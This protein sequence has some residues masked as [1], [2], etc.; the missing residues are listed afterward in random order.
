MNTKIEIKPIDLTISPNIQKIISMQEW[1]VNY[2]SVL[3]A[4]QGI[5]IKDHNTPFIGR[6]A[7]LI[8]GTP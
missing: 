8:A 3:T 4:S 6:K 5:K 1:T 7:A 2:M